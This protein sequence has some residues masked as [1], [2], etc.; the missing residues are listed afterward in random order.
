MSFQEHEIYHL[1]SDLWRDAHPAIARNEVAVD[2]YLF[3][4]DRDSRRGLTV[5]A[6]VS[7]EVSSR[8][9]HFLDSLKRLEPDQYYTR[10]EELHVTVLAL[11][12]ATEQYQPYFSKEEDYRQAVRE[13]LQDA[14]AFTLAFAGVT[15]SRGVIMVQGFPQG[16]ALNAI[17]QS[18]R[19]ALGRVGLG[20]GLDN[21]YPIR[22]AHLSVAR[23]AA[24]LSAPER[25]ADFLLAH[26]ETDFGG[27]TVRRLETVANDWYLSQDR[28]T[29]LDTHPLLPQDD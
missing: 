20:H 5:L 2:P 11:F 13:A 26:R 23:F 6:R 18:L 12:T 1:Y 8:V 7:P 22:A 27:T 24:P 3:N 9:A 25:T 17:R 10:P 4:K 16:E 28:V 29:L 21:R 15:A 14:P 19:N